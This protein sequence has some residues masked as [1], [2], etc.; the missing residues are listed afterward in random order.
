M[1]RA[2][3]PVSIAL[4]SRFCRSHSVTLPT[5]FKLAWSLVLQI[6]NGSDSACFGYLVSG[7][8]NLGT[9]GHMK[10]NAFGALA[11]ILACRCDLSGT[12]GS[13]LNTIHRDSLSDLEHQYC[14]LAHIQ[15]NLDSSKLANQQPLFNTI[16][17]FQVHP[18]TASSES[19]I[20]LCKFYVY[21]PTEYSCVVDI[22][23]T[24]ECFEI[25]LT[26]RTSSI[27]RGQA[28]NIAE[29][30]LTAL[31]ALVQSLVTMPVKGINLFGQGHS[32]QVWAWNRIVPPRVDMCIHDVVSRNAAAYPHSSAIESRDAIFTYEELDVATTQLASHLAHLGVGPGSIVPLCFAKSAWTIVSLLAVLKAGGAFV[33]LDPNHITP[34]R[35]GG[36]IRD[37]GPKL[38]IAGGQRESLLLTSTIASTTTAPGVLVVD[39]DCM[40]RIGL[41]SSCILPHSRNP[42]LVS[43]QDPAYIFFTSGTT[44]TPKG[45][46]NTHSGFCTAAASWW[47]RTGLSNRSRVLQYASYTFDAC[48]SEILT[49]LLFGGCVCVPTEEERTENI[50]GAI[51]EARVDVALLTPSVARLITPTEVPALEILFL[52]GEAVTKADAAHWKGHV[53][54]ANSYGPSECGVATTVNECILDDTTNI[55]RPTDSLCWIVDPEN[56]ERLV[57]IGAVGELII[58]GHIVANGYLNDEAKTAESFIKPPEWLSRKRLESG[59]QV[60][61]R[62]YKTGDLVRHNS[63]GSIKFIGRKDTQSKLH[64]QR[65]ELGEVEHHVLSQ[66]FVV[67]AVAVEVIEPEVCQRR[68]ALAAFFTWSGT[69]ANSVPGIPDDS[70]MF[71]DLPDDIAIHLQA[72]QDSLTNALPSYMIPTLFVPLSAFPLSPS[73]KLDRRALRSAAAKIPVARLCQYSLAGVSTGRQA[74]KS[75][76]E[77]TLHRAWVETLGSPPEMIDRNTSFFRAGGDSLNAMRLVSTA[78]HKYGLI[79]SVATIFEHPRLCDMAARVVFHDRGQESDTSTPET[80]VEAFGLLPRDHSVDSLVSIAAVQCQVRQESVLDLYPCTPLQEGLM[81]ISVDKKGA[82]LRQNIYRI[83]KTLNVD[84]LKRAWEVV[85]TAHPILR[86]RI[87]SIDSIETVGCLQVV[88]DDQITWLHPTCSRG[89]YLADDLD[90]PVT[91]GSPLNRFAIL[92]PAHLNDN[93]AYLVWTVHHAVFDEWSLRLTM[94]QLEQAYHDETLPTVLPFNRFIK[95]TTNSEDV[96]CA[97]FWAEELGGNVP[98]TLPQLP[99]NGYVPRLGDCDER[100]ID[101]ARETGQHITTPILLRAS[102]ALV[103]GRY[104]ATEDI[105]FGASVH[106]R[107]AAVP[108]IDKING[109][110]MATVPVKESTS[111]GN[112]PSQAS[113]NAF[114]HRPPR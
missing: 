64:G 94:E 114:R 20:E 110:T 74:P 83:P 65:M 108:G 16:L 97:A 28:E 78:R 85:V 87:V 79:L 73:K 91:W 30:F 4:L 24:G 113:L 40:S 63:D 49:V 109:P 59:Q 5:A 2:T 44:G 100:I 48:L 71:L 101:L 41:C 76:T 88:L 107:S 95:Y 104:A 84:R 45:S 102:W 56:H 60:L 3:S 37:T 70:N 15:R 34:G 46:V 82:Y 77:K 50:V 72:L 25:S 99:S 53:K 18:N 90:L 57:P 36:I 17:N 12:I 32:K 75:D 47:K 67:R 80:Q 58:E 7:R 33:L 54:L 6:Y 69:V 10:D 19:S 26:H 106:G 112:S 98:V 92:A 23:A 103:T 62:V 38:L 27:S 9:D 66:S 96:T 68:Q 111:G 52:C 11:N 22:V 89:Q 35:T 61:D 42:S 13:L 21:E 1:I 55:G 29:A 86:T 39:K 51:N 93:H 43:P 14:S 105:V 8:D 31:G 81:A